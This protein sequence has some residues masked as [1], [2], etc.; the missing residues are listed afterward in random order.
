VY[1]KETMLN[2][3]NSM[4]II[5]IKENPSFILGVL[6]SRLTSYWFIHR[7]GKMQRGTFPQFK[8]N[9]LK[10]FPIPQ[11]TDAQQAPLVA[12]VN[13]ILALHAGTLDASAKARIDLL[14]AEIDVLVYQLY[15]LTYDDV[16]VIDPDFEKKKPRSEYESGLA[17]T[18]DLA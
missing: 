2:D 18:G 9:E 12:R 14:E 7:F 11:A 3:R 13:D 1:T 8:I 16:L 6:N 4:N 5:E 15:Q 10:Q 17:P